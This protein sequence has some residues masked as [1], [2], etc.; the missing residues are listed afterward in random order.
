MHL[1]VGR[2]RPVKTSG[3]TLRQ[4]I[5]KGAERR[6]ESYALDDTEP[7]NCAHLR[8][9]QVYKPCELS[10]QARNCRTETVKYEQPS[11]EQH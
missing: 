4:D 2:L 10:V 7:S 6:F 8:A 1:S 3:S 11:A 9:R 5:C